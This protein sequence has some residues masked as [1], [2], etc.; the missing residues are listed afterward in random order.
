[1]DVG[2]NERGRNQSTGSINFAIGAMGGEVTG[3]A[4]KVPILYG[5]IDKALT[6]VKLRVTHEKIVMHKKFLFYHVIIGVSS[7]QY[8]SDIINTRQE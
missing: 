1:M 6:T 5:D 8:S 2:I 4:S 3:N 7:W